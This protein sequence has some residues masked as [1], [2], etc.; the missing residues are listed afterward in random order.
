MTLGPVPEQTPRRRISAGDRR[1]MIVT[2]ATGV[3]GEKG[4][5]AAGVADIAR[6]AGVSERLLYKHFPAGKRELFHAA[7]ERVTEMV[8]ERYRRAPVGAAAALRQLYAGRFAPPGAP[9]ALRPLLLMR[10]HIGAD[11]PE[12]RQVLRASSDR[13]QAAVEDYLIGQ[14]QRGAIRPELDP[15]ALAWIW[16][17]ILRGR[18]HR[19]AVLP[20]DELTAVDESILDQ[21]LDLI[22]TDAVSSVM[23]STKQDRM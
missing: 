17:A 11:D 16:T 7:I 23:E 8:V 9:G 10:A 19:Q 5:A 14:Q 13:V 3:F 1:A 6:A 2:A 22:L 18:D 12:T 4:Y 20:P 21:F 15:K